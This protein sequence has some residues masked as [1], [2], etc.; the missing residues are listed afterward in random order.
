MNRIRA[1]KTVWLCCHSVKINLEWAVLDQKFETVVSSITPRLIRSQCLN[2]T[3]HEAHA[4]RDFRLFHVLEMSLS[5]FI[6]Y[7][8]MNVFSFLRPLFKYH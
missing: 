2:G 3:S 4:Y 7:K 1:R 5:N 8:V 6:R